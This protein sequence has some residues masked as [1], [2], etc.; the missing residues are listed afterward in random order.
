MD[1][2]FL[3][4]SGLFLGAF[5]LFEGD[6]DEDDATK[7]EPHK[8][9]EPDPTPVERTQIIGTAEPDAITGTDGNDLIF[10]R[11]D[12]DRIDGA[13]GNDLL[14]GGADDD[15]I[16][17]NL[18]NDV[19][20]GNRGADLILGNRGNDI[21]DG[22]DG[23]DLLFGGLGEDQLNGEDGDDFLDGGY[24]TSRPLTF[25]EAEAVLRNG[26]ELPDGVTEV[27]DDKR[28]DRLLGG[29]GNDALVLGDGDRGF[30]GAGEDTYFVLD[31]TLQRDPETG[32]EI[33]F[34][35]DEDRLVVVVP[36]GS[37]PM[38]ELD[39]SGFDAPRLLS[40][41]NVIATL[42]L[43]EGDVVSLSDISVVDTAGNAIVPASDPPL[44][45]IGTPDDDSITGASGDDTLS[46]RQGE[47]L[48]QGL[49]GDD[50]LS[51]GQGDDTLV[52]GDGGD[53]LFGNKGS[54]LLLGGRGAD[55]LGGLQDDD[56][57]LGGEDRDFL[58]GNDGNDILDGSR[59]YS[60]DLTLEEAIAIYRDGADLP[61]GVAVT[62]DDNSFDF[63]RGGDGDDVLYLGE[64][65]NGSGQEGSDTYIVNGDAFQSDPDVT[66]QA[67]FDPQEDKLV[68]L[69]P[70][71]T[72]PT[73]ELGQ[74]ERG[75][76]LLLSN[77]QGI[78][79][80]SLPMNTTFSVADVEVVDTAGNAVSPNLIEPV[81]IIGT[82]DA[83]EIV[84][85]R[86]TDVIDGQ[87]QRDV[88]LGL[89]GDDRINGGFWADV[90]FGGNGDDQ[91][92]GEAGR[93][94]LFGGGGDDLIL[95]GV[96]D[97]ILQGG[98][99]EDTLVGGDGDDIL[100]GTSALSRDL[101]LE[102]VRDLRDNGVLPDDVTVST[103]D[104][105]FDDL[106]GEDGDDVLFLGDR[107]E[108]SGGEGADIFVIN[109]DGLQRGPTVGAYIE[110]FRPGVDTLQVLTAEGGTPVLTIEEDAGGLTQI[111]SNGT[112]I[113]SLFD[114]QA[115]AISLADIEIAELVQSV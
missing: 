1:L 58:I 69:V 80:L 32:A 79:R 43:A 20:N 17:G 24:H 68:V 113:A 44:Q 28:P 14:R 6:D 13:A 92:R 10:G 84:G 81:I 76:P 64:G 47:D 107:D 8:P 104:K 110:D 100:D 105:T 50:T 39:S 74:D 61:D 86:F 56:I 101:T 73:I 60:R 51:G 19:A 96:A 59:T 62:Y 22:S 45:I 52:G 115:S 42:R 7:S 90:I 95:G 9:H 2:L 72:V 98:G 31:D 33:G 114:V 108:A 85:T 49:D 34:V 77:G 99:G 88:I 15:T 46:G 12:A 112:V 83:D 67:F 11:A 25:E 71:G 87:G 106:S 57:L 111:L 18:G 103:D 93:D 63:L 21:L 65:D 48:I 66:A 27:F 38:L 55:Y 36:E 70:E 75:A 94:A 37:E 109:D 23:G 3:L 41:G 53:T 16:F 82:A 78:V 29:F 102:E 89:D 5:G 91:L 40:N 54:D 35:P 97:D 26:G 30:A 4:A